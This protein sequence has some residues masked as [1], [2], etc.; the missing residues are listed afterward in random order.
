VHP[1]V[2]LAAQR[3]NAAATDDKAKKKPRY[4]KKQK[5]GV[6]D[7]EEPGAPTERARAG[8]KRSSTMPLK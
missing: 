1:L 7:A 8:G 5:D 2:L 3:I 4:G 6:A